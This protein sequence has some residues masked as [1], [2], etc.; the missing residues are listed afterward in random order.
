M[1]E[2]KGGSGVGGKKTLEAEVIFFAYTHIVPAWFS[3]SLTVEPAWQLE[4]K[5]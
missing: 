1:K 5:W 3:L 4:R 2:W